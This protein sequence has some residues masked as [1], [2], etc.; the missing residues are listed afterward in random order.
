VPAAGM[1][2]GAPFT[3]RFSAPSDALTQA[4]VKVTMYAPPFTTHGYSMNQRLLVLSVT[5]FVDEGR[6]HTITVDAPGKPELAPPGYYMVFLVA[7]DVPS[8]AV[9]VKIQ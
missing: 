8:I 4:D 2:Y 9:W 1:R 5:V 6:S 3:F 7:K